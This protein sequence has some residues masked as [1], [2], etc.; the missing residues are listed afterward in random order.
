MNNQLTIVKISGKQIEDEALFQ[1]TMLDFYYL[2]RPK[3]MIHGGGKQISKLLDERGL[4]NK[5]HKGLRI[6]TAEALPV[7]LEVARKLNNKIVDTLNSWDLVGKTHVGLKG[8]GWAQT[9]RSKKI[10]VLEDGTD[11][12]FVGEMYE[13]CVNVKT[14]SDI[15]DFENTPVISNITWCEE[16]QSF[17]NTNADPLAEA[18]AS[19]IK[20]SYCKNV[21]LYMLSDVP[22]VL[23]NG[24]IVPVM[25]TQKFNQLKD[26]EI[27]TDG[28]LLKCET[29]IKLAAE[30]G[31]Q[32]V[33]A[34]CLKAGHGTIVR[35]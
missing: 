21:V 30:S 2:R 25:D 13:N 28:M 22:G 3:I 16:L 24:K 1:Q 9:I 32:I 4:F 19:Q 20:S 31:I 17:M 23:E 14:I 26:D 5:T 27:I 12:H 29:T 33:I 15:L 10:P 7:V 35:S 8:E 34:N 6:T 11:Y 18:V